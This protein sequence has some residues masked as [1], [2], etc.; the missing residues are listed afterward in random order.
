M[1]KQNNILTNFKVLRVVIVVLMLSLISTHVFAI[2]ISGKIS[3]SDGL[4]LYGTTVMIRSAKE[5]ING[6]ATDEDGFF[7][8]SI[9]S[10]NTQPFW[11]YIST[12]G[13]QSDSLL[14]V[15]DKTTYNFVLSP[16]VVEVG[17]VSVVSNFNHE[18]D[19]NR[20]NKDKVDTY[21]ARS[22]VPT[23]PIS[24]IRQPQLIREGSN[25]SSKLRITGTSPK[26]FINSVD[27]GYNPNHYGIFS[28]IPSSV[29][30]SLDFFPDGTSAQYGLPS[31]LEFNTIE[32]YTPHFD[33]ELNISLLEST[34]SFSIGKKNFF[35]LGSLRKSVL[36]KVLNVLDVESDRA[37]IPPTNFQ[38][39]F[40][41]TGYRLSPTQSFV[42]D[43][44]HAR[45]YLA[46]N[47]G[48]TRNNSAG[49]NTYQHTNEHYIGARYSGMFKH[50]LLNVSL[51]TRF[52]LEQY[53]AYPADMTRPSGVD[54]DL[55]ARFQTYSSSVDL[56]TQLLQSE[57]TVGFETQYTAK[58]DIELS[59]TNWNFLPPDANS[60][61]PYIFQDVLNSQYG[62]FTT[63]NSY[64]DGSGYFSI[65]HRR[66]AFEIES[67]LRT[68][69]FSALNNPMLLLHRN[70]I[71]W[72][73]SDEKKMSLFI[74]TFAENPIRSIL[75]P[76]QVI[77][78]SHPEYLDPI[79]TR[80]LLVSYNQG[81]LKLK[82]FSKK[83]QNLPLSTPVITSSVDPRTTTSTSG[84]EKI[85]MRS[86][87]S[88]EFY[89]VDIAYSI[90]DIIH[91]VDFYGFYGYSYAEKSAEYAITGLTTAPYEFNA[92]H[93]FLADITWRTSQ[94]ITLGAEMSLRSGYSYTPTYDYEQYSIASQSIATSLDYASS[95]ENSSRFP[96]NMS[97]NF[98]AEFDLGHST[99]Y[100]NVANI[101]NSSNPM[102]NT[103]NGFI[104]DAGILPSFGYRLK[105]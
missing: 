101:T 66:G 83:I 34:A 48:T 97:L 95:L 90:S 26:Y 87:S 103:S 13:Y 54:L 94:S 104:Y 86:A 71:T 12:I 18:V 28:V 85:E 49:T 70:R 64:N 100:M 65:N 80:L 21:A 78:Q 23:N 89:G 84:V 42:I 62:N 29:V 31:I 52:G 47:T 24:A 19:M 75:S 61:N 15:P 76:Y 93:K 37:T 53:L 69:W 3:D 33:G 38:D 73:I 81:P 46:V 68:E 91:D 39:I 44:Y 105:F 16:I 51:S 10:S 35:A 79:H 20:M 4:P 77:I 27:I 1:N 40:L 92:P 59:Q 32:N 72:R 6:T 22:F 98:H 17:M 2:S 63:T 45:D 88:V 36:D 11:L 58:R 99:I 43:Q 50:F 96:V 41:S 67:G 56:T 7:S 74:G 9:D 82:V 55:Y 57:I 102:I 60:D 25:H 14:I 30:Q 8:L 5:Y